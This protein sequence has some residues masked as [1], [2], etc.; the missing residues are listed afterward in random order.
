MV[1]QIEPSRLV[2]LDPDQLAALLGSPAG[3]RDEPPATVWS[4][5]SDLCQLD[6]FL[7]MSVE[8]K[9]LKALAYDLKAPTD[10]NDCVDSIVADNRDRR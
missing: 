6:V 5:R 10:K 9:A 4:Y 2:G 3:V 8:T 1:P 7:F